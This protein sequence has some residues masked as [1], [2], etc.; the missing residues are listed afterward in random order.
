V[1]LLG[2]EVDASCCQCSGC[3]GGG[4]CSDLGTGGC[5]PEDEFLCALGC[6]SGGCSG[7]SIINSACV[8]IAACGFATET[9]PVIGAPGRILLALMFIGI[10]FF[11]LRRRGTPRAVRAAVVVA[12][13][14]ASAV[15]IDAAFQ[16]QV[17]GTWEPQTPPDAISTQPSWAATLQLG[18]DGSLSGP[19]EVAGSPRL[20]R[21]IF[22]GQVSNRQVTG[23]ITV[24]GTTVATVVGTLGENGLVGQY[25]TTDGKTGAFTW[26]LPTS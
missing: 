19:I 21:G 23:T 11:Y 1:L 9:A 13:V 22:A 12:I 6:S 5:D 14:A 4:L 25:T 24:D 16:L 10:G 17:S 7:G 3:D 15:A 20:N 2:A 18:D 26:P 8:S